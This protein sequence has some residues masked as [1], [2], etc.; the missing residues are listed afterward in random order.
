MWALITDTFTTLAHNLL[1]TWPYAYLKD[2]LPSLLVDKNLNLI[3]VSPKL[4]LM[5]KESHTKSRFIDNHKIEK[6]G[7]YIKLRTDFSY[8]VIEQSI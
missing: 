3:T 1:K 5:G 7:T 6:V 8:Q 2:I 4:L